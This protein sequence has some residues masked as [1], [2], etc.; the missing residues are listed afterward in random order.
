MEQNFMIFAGLVWI[1]TIL[2]A[3]FNGGH[4]RKVIEDALGL[5]KTADQLHNKTLIVN[6][7]QDNIQQYECTLK[8]LQQH[9]KWTALHLEKI[10]DNKEVLVTVD[11]NIIYRGFYG[12]SAEVAAKEYAASRKIGMQPRLEYNP[13]DVAFN[14][15]TEKFIGAG[16]STTERDIN[17]KPTPP[18][19]KKKTTFKSTTKSTAKITPKKKTKSIL[20]G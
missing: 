5:Q 17:Y 1:A 7:L 3:M 12:S 20:L 16:V 6:I 19:K 14:F 10:N 4:Y 15:D 13:D 11:G 8:A 2:I 9:F 18:V